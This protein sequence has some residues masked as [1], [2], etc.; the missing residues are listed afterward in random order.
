MDNC[1]NVP[2]P[3]A[4]WYSSV[5]GLTELRKIWRPARHKAGN[6]GDVPP[7]QALET[8]ATD[9]LS[10]VYRPT[11]HIIGHIG[12]RFLRVKWPNRQCQSTE[13]SSS[14]KDRLQSHQ[15][16]LIVLQAYT[17]MQYIHKTESKH[18]ETGPVRQNPIQRTVRSVHVETISNTTKANSCR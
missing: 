16:H 7:S 15:V 13:G 1:L 11:K 8:V 2:F 9:W 10:R 4:T 14:P 18:S 5:T 12:D 3:A 6:F 17:C